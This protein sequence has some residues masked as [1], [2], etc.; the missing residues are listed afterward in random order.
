M[1]LIAMSLFFLYKYVTQ[2]NSGINVWFSVMALIKQIFCRIINHIM[3]CLSPSFLLSS[4]YIP[5]VAVFSPFSLPLL[6][7]H[8]HQNIT[9]QRQQTKST[10]AN[11]SVHQKIIR[12]WELIAC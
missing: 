3:L 8:A 1:L 2:Y 9:P 12:I 4:P 6:T 10:W 5:K 11:V 7:T